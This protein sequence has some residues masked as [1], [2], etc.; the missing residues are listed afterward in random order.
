M[1]FRNLT[2]F[3][4]PTTVNKSLKALE[5]RLAEV[6]LKPVGPLDMM[7]R[8][9]V[10]PFG[11]DE[12]VLSHQV[13]DCVLFTLGGED[14]I[15]PSSV[16]NDLVNKKIAAI[17]EKQGRKLGGKARR[18]LKED[19]VHELLPRAFVRSTRLNAYIDMEHGFVAIDSSS[20]KSAENLVS[21]LRHALGSFPAIPLNAETSP[22]T[23]MTGWI[24]GEKLP[25]GLELG[26]ECELKDGDERGAIVKCQRQ[27][28]Q[29][30]EI[31]KHLE[32]GKQVSRLGLVL[33]A[34]VSFVL[35][36]DLV[37][38]KLKFLDG[39]V[40][41]L[42]NTD[43][44]DQSAELDARFALMSAEIKRLFEVMEKNLKLSKAEA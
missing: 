10:S 43:Q 35:G 1:F 25:K 17:E 27:E 28:L 22:R 34:H 39:A 4:F 7:S 42:E 14:K 15:L 9:F 24:S 16:V 20:R 11:R 33:D 44:E 6:I 18:A 8:G 41:S 37:I 5:E 19:T 13:G 40:E 2:L 3:R 12:A 36:E 32:S 23:V 38:R 21:E 29:T 30:D 26:E 31:K